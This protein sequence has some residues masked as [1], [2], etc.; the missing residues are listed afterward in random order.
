MLAVQLAP[1]KIR[2]NA[3]AP[4]LFPSEMTTGKSG[5]D[6]KAGVFWLTLSERASC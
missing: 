3:I 5:S 1:T 4:G 2:V 6:Q